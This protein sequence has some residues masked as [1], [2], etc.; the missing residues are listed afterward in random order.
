MESAGA[1]G[2]HSLTTR[3]VA[4][5][6]SATGNETEFGRREIPIKRLNAFSELFL[7]SLFSPRPHRKSCCFFFNWN[8]NF[9]SFGK[10]LGAHRSWDRRLDSSVI[11][12]A[13]VRDGEGDGVLWCARHQPLGYRGRDQESVLHQGNWFN[14]DLYC[15][16]QIACDR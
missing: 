5:L 13:R 6:R 1:V 2:A 11:R 3:P 14:F 16:V 4:R 7:F 12:S 9:S 8:W 15:T 10:K